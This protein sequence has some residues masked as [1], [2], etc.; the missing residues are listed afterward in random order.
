MIGKLAFAFAFVLFASVLRHASSRSVHGEDAQGLDTLELVHVVFRHGDRTPDKHVIYKNDPYINVTYYPIGHG[1]LTN[2]GK[3]KEYN[4]GKELRKRYYDFLGKDFTL[5]TVDARCTDYNR[6]KMSLQLV[7]A[8]L[9]PPR[10]D[11]VW[12]NSINWQPVPFNYWPVHE[13]HV[14]ADP[15]KN[16]PKYN[17]LFWGFLNST[18]GKRLYEN[19]T[20]LIEDLETHTGQKLNSK[21]FAELYFTLTT[22]KENGYDHPQWA[23]DVYHHILQLAIKD[24]NV[25]TFNAELKKYCT[26]F[27]V[28]KIIDD[29]LTKAKGEYFKDTKI[30]LYSAHE[31]NVA[32]L[33][34][35]LGVFYPHVPPYGS[36]VV[37]EVHNVNGIRGLKFFYQDYTSDKPRR[38]KIPGC[39][40]FCKLRKFI[41]LHDHMLPRSENECFD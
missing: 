19:Y 11:L 32:V 25:S 13:D 14:L 29:S 9:F 40:N 18:E 37:I 41:Q 22:E 34:R 38:L 24:Y 1:Q 10:G 6:T 8:S 2:A 21:A 12:E 28:K 36:Y 35:F 33:L 3:R 30:F 39:G 31:F 4:I 20:Q 17:R 7:L 23:K 16:C 27:L 26:G 15:L 5:D